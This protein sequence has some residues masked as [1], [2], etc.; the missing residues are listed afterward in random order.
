[1]WRTIKQ[2]MLFFLLLMCV[3]FLSGCKTTLLV[4]N[5][6]VKQTAQILKDYAGTHGYQITFANEQ[7]GSYR[8]DMGSVFMP[9]V[10]Q[11]VKNKSSIQY[12]PSASQPMTAYE[13]TT[14]NTVS[15]PAHYVQA[16]AAVTILQQDNDVLVILDGNDAAG[17]SL[18]DFRDYVQALGYT[19]DVK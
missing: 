19:V 17:S 1:M 9:Y 13:Q 4:H 11:T 12:A 15:D 14:W 8:L 16:S 5:A 10:S 18:N 3:L 2:L 7:T 6:T